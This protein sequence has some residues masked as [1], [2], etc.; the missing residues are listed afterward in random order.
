[1]RVPGQ[2]VLLFLAGAPY[3]ALCGQSGAQAQ[4]SGPSGLPLPRFLSLKSDKVNVRGGPSRDHAVSWT[5]VKEGLPV[6]I[7]Q[8]FDNW[9]RIRD[10]A[11]DDGWVFHKLLSGGRTVL[12]SPDKKTGLISVYETESK[13]SNLVAWLEPRVVVNLSRCDGTW[14]RIDVET[15]TG[16]IEQAEIY[17]VYPKEQ[18]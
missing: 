18:F 2:F 10:F 7:I 17:G 4:R 6:E 12:V 14:C 11:G 3:F 15:V 13:D 8:E 9:R 5:F 1:M 16:W